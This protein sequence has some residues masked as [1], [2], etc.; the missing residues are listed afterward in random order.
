M[1]LFAMVTTAKSKRYT[2]YALETFFRF[3]SLNPEDRFVLIDN[4][5]VSFTASEAATFSPR[6]EVVANPE[7]IGFAANCNAMLREAKPSQADLYFLNND[8]IFSESWLEPL[9]LDEPWILSPLSNREV[10]YSTEHFRCETAMQLEEYV[11]KEEIFQA[12][13]RTHKQATTGHY[14]VIVAPFFAIKIPYAV[15]NDLGALDEE[16]GRGGGEDYDYCVRAVLAGYK[17]KYAL[18]SYILHFG[19]K[20]SWSGVETRDEQDAREARFRNRFSEKWGRYLADLILY[21]N[22]QLI[23]EFPGMPEKVASGDLKGVVE[24]LIASA[25]VNYTP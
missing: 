7:P 18:Q 11:G 20:S 12:L 15:Y 13:C 10:R 3:T 14:N 2:P 1:K 23:A 4:D 19:G 25:G 16:Y 22:Q 8:L 17:V 9:L 24:E 6:V 21:E 5:R